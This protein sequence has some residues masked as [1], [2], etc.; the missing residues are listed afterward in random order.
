MKELIFVSIVRPIV[1]ER[2][3]TITDVTPENL[4]PG[5]ITISTQYQLKRF[6]TPSYLIDS[7]C[8]IKRNCNKTGRWRTT[9][10]SVRRFSN[11]RKI[12]DGVGK[13]SQGTSLKLAKQ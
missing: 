7:F 2:K 11:G 1:F 10:G 3:R 5:R 8:N 12:S 6:I 4:W 13:L 9:M